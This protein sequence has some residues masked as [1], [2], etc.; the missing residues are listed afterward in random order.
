MRARDAAPAE[1]GHPLCGVDEFD[2]S[3]Q[4]RVP[5][6]HGRAV[7]R[8]GQL[9]RSLGRVPARDVPGQ[10]YHRHAAPADGVLDRR[11]DHARHLRG[12]GDQLQ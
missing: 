11:L 5:G 9:G 7:Q 6:T 8:N 10:G 4:L 1:Q 3:R 12:V 2:Q